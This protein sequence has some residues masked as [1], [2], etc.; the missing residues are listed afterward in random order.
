MAEIHIKTNSMGLPCVVQCCYEHH[1]HDGAPLSLYKRSANTQSSILDH[2][3][4]GPKISS[5]RRF[6]AH[7][8]L[9]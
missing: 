6:S 5:K 3:N 7:P 9:G 8:V 1:T 4:S 2:K